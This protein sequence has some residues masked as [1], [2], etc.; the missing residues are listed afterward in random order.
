MCV[1]SCFLVNGKVAYLICLD[2][3]IIGLIGFDECHYFLDAKNIQFDLLYLGGTHAIKPIPITNHF[4]KVKHTYDAHA[5]IYSEQMFDLA[6]HFLSIND[7]VYDHFLVDYIQPRGLS[8]C[9]PKD[10]CLQY[11]NYSDGLSK[12]VKNKYYGKPTY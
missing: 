7:F 8:F 11:D 4:H 3:L 9:L 1:C 10:I 6:L 2:V 5:V 12:P